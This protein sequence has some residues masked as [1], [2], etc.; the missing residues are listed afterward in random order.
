MDFDPAYTYRMPVAF[1][2]LPGPRQT[3]PDSGP[4]GGEA[5]LRTLTLRYETT[6]EALR[7]LLPPC[8]EPG[9]EPFVTVEYTELSDVPWLAGR[10]YDTFAVKLPARF[11]GHRDR[12]TGS[13]VAVVWENMA[14]PIITGREE[15][16]YAKLYADL[17]S[18]PVGR[19]GHRCTASWDGHTF[20]EL[21]LEGITDV[22]PAPAVQ[23][24]GVLNFRYVPG[25][26]AS[27]PDAM[28]PVLTPAAGGAHVL[29]QATAGGRVRFVKSAWEQL[30][31]F[32]PIVNTLERL[33]VLSYGDCVIRDLR[34]D[35]EN[36]GQRRLV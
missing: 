27:E 5:T 4:R 34:R 28:G 30:P 26:D 1:G 17:H 22:P 18:A 6:P 19:S 33:P 15:L 29:R 31:T 20:A 11:D 10:G 8:F 16:G 36:R 21:E 13:F 7:E 25:V 35:I 2:P 23:G 32:Y 24:A 9:G 12:V 14:D 3:L